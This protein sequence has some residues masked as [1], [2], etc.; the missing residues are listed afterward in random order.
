M[1]FEIEKLNKETIL[2]RDVFDYL[3]TIIDH[4]QHTEL[5]VQLRSRL[6]IRSCT[7]FDTL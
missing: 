4:V 2:E 5:L 6:K 3:F 1:P 7:G